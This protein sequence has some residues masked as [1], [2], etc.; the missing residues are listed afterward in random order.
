M[1]FCFFNSSNNRIIKLKHKRKQRDYNPSNLT[2]CVSH[3]DHCRL[4]MENTYHLHFCWN[5]SY[6][7]HLVHPLPV[8]HIE[9]SVIPKYILPYLKDSKE[10]RRCKHWKLFTSIPK[11]SKLLIHITESRQTSLPAFTWEKYKAKFQ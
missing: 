2:P 5:H 9:N 8:L 7:I 11:T 6:I 1:I 10:S 3:L 4:T